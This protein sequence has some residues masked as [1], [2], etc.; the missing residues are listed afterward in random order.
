MQAVKPGGA[1][2]P[3]DQPSPDFMVQ[4]DGSHSFNITSVKKK[5]VITVWILSLVDAEMVKNDK[6]TC[7]LDDRQEEDIRNLN[8]AI[9]EFRL[10]F[11]KKEDRREFDLY[12]PHALKKDLPARLSDNDPR[13][14]VSGVQRLMGEDLTERNRRNEQ[15]EQLRE[16]SLQQQRERQEALEDKKLAGKI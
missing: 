3:L 5:E 6:I 12:D 4:P 13:C 16:W 10:C 8:K 1:T 14:S 7:L 2:A 9:N 11:Q 15:Q